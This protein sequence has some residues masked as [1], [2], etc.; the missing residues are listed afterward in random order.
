M[1]ALLYL[2]PVIVI[3][4]IFLIEILNY[5]PNRKISLQNKQKKTSLLS[6]NPVLFNLLIMVACIVK[7]K[8]MIVPKGNT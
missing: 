8:L 3:R 6:N 4:I 5:A 7:P 2:F 1:T